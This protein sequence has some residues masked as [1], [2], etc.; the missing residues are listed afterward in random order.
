MKFLR[1]LLGVSKLGKVNNQGFRQKTG[2]GS[3]E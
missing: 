1:Q 2:T 3:I